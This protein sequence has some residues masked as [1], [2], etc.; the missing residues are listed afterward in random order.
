MTHDESG[1]AAVAWVSDFLKGWLPQVLVAGATVF[2]IVWGFHGQDI[3]TSGMW[4]F[5]VTVGLA[6]LAVAAQVLVQRP[7][8]MT[9]AKERGELDELSRA[10]GDAL[11]RSMRVLLRKLSEHCTVS[12]STTRASAYCFHD[13]AFVMIARFSRNPELERPGRRRYPAD[14]GAI[15]EA[16]KSAS[17]AIA[18]D[19]PPTEAAWLRSLGRY[20]FSETESRGLAMRCVEIGAVR[21]ETQTGAVEVL[22]LES[23]EPG[24][25]DYSTL[26]AV[27]ASL[28]FAA[29]AEAVGS[30]ALMTPRGRSAATASTT[31][32][33]A[34]NWQST[35][36]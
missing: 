9:L 1:R 36:P 8:Y 7:S 19:L 28:I 35:K 10:Q 33:P 3:W 27:R 5:I 2:S 29:R 26:E 22:V 13:D 14:Q 32:T 23:N 11:E 15:G 20:N 34:P 21:F 31:R 24:R 18:I 25:I 6:L 17:G 4:A 30:F 12:A 16:W